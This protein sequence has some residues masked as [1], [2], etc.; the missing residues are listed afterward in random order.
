MLLGETVNSINRAQVLLSY[1]FTFYLAVISSKQ[2]LLLY[3]KFELVLCCVV[4]RCYVSCYVMLCYVML[5]CV[6]LR[7]VML[8][9]Y[10]MFCCVTLR[11]YVKLRYFT[12][13]YVMCKLNHDLMQSNDHNKLLSLNICF[14]FTPEELTKLERRYVLFNHIDLGLAKAR[15]FDS[16]VSDNNEL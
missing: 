9:C 8:S 12:L 10:V 7:Y 2:P 14:Y 4:L 1:V 11:C 15:K 5:C 13:C 16:M 6:V 3:D